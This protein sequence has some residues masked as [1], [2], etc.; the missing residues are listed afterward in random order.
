MW[1]FEDAVTFDEVDVLVALD[2][3]VG[4]LRMLS[5]MSSFRST[6]ASMS[7]SM[8]PSIS[9]PNSS[10]RRARVRDLCTPEHRLRRD[11][12]AIE[13]RPAEE[14]LLDECYV[15]PA[16]PALHR[17]WEARHSAA[18]DDQIVV[19]VCHRCGR[20][21]WFVSLS[22]SRRC[23]NSSCD[24]SPRAYAT[25]SSSTAGSPLLIPA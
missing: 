25:L 7:G 17:D 8:A 22:A 16:V 12:A 24:N 3:L 4:P 23:S 14:A 2:V 18:G 11:A 5:T 21:Y 15:H 10:L 13:T 9:I 20:F 6:M 1:G 19:S